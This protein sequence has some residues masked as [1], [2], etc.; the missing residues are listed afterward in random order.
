MLPASDYPLVGCS[1]AEPTSVLSD[2]LIV[3]LDNG[4]FQDPK[5]LGDVLLKTHT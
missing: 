5:F 3:A 1:P 4:K 2:K